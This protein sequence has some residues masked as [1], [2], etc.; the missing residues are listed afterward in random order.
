M[1]GGVRCAHLGVTPEQQ[2]AVVIRRL[3][4]GSAHAASHSAGLAS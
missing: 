4:T 3:R 1:T 2:L